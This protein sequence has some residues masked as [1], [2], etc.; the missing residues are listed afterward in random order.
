M[1]NYSETKL[2]ELISHDQQ[3]NPVV[4]RGH[5]TQPLH[6]RLSE[7]HKKYKVWLKDNTK[8]YYSSYEVLKHG[9]ARIELVRVIHCNNVME[10]KRAEGLFIREAPCVNKYI[11]GRTLKEWNDE[12]KDKISEDHKKYYQEHKD[13]IKAYCKKYHQE[14]KDEKKAYKKKYREEHKE[15]FKQKH[16]NYYQENKEKWSEKVTCECGIEI[17]RVSLL[18]HCKSKK[19]LDAVKKK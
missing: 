15:E 8:A 2:Y 18:R 9:N 12:H 14:H 16:K 6:K 13:E 3:G 7:H 1:P 17:Q 4:Y 19:H 10:A 5:T 11:A